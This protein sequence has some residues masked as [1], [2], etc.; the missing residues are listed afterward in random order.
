MTTLLYNN[1]SN[2]VKEDSRKQLLGE[3]RPVLF[4][5]QFP[6]ILGD[7]GAVSRVDEMSVVKVYF[8][9]ETSPCATTPTEPVPEAVELPASDWPEFVSG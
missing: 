6:A 2:I 7:P 3:Q 5:F 9:I 8:K 1:K 4:N